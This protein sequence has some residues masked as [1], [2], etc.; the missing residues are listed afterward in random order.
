MKSS[1]PLPSSG[2]A[3]HR[4]PGE[5]RPLAIAALLMLSGLAPPACGDSAPKAPT[6][7]E[8]VSI[9]DV[10]DGACVSFSDDNACVAELEVRAC[11]QAHDV[12]VAGRYTLTDATYPGRSQLRLDTQLACLPIFEAYVGTD[13]YASSFELRPISPSPSSWSV[14]DRT[15]LC[16]VVS[17][18]GQ[19]LAT[20]ARGSGR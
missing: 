8:R 6:E 14:G 19:P 12:E 3:P 2:S 9:R 11:G 5:R 20:V 10:A 16:L 7:A 17:E 4:R 18:D 13:Y 15:V 1:L